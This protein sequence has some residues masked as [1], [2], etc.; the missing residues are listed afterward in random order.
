MTLYELTNN[1]IDLKDLLINGYIDETSYADTLESLEFDTEQKLEGYAQLIRQLEA[2]A[3][4]HKME[5]DWHTARR[6]ARENAVARLKER[7]GSHLAA[8]GQEKARAGLFSFGWHKS[9]AV[10]VTD[11]EQLTS[12]L[13]RVI[14]E[15]DKTAIKKAIQSGEEVQGAQIVERRSVVLR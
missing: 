13:F 11:E 15:P 7:I 8:T 12:A 9:S 5:A 3:E 14:R 4:A 2:E 1:L 10:E 6:K